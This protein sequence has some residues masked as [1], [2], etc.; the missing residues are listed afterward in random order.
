MPAT[1]SGRLNVFLSHRYHSPAENEYFWQLLSA[2]E[3]V[4]FRVDE[5]V[6]FTSPV[7]LERLIREADGFVGVHPLTGGHRE[8]HTRKSLRHESRYF[9]LELSMAVRARKPAVVFHDHRLEPALKAPPDVRFVGYDPQEIDSATQSSLPARVEAAYR[10]FLTDAHAASPPLGVGPTYQKRRVGLV[11]SLPNQQ[12]LVP[13]LSEVLH[14]HAWEPV[15]QPWPPRMNLELITWLRQ[16]DWVVIDL[17]DT[18]SRLVAAFTHGQFIPTLPVASGT[19]LDTPGTSVT[20]EE[21]LYGDTETGHRKAIIRWT[22]PTQLMHAFEAHLGVIDEQS[23]YIGR[24]DQAT[25]YFRSAAKRNERVFLSYAAEDGEQAA[26]F[27]QL[28]NDRFQDVFDYRSYGA[29]RV[30][31]P[32]MDS[33]LSGLARSAVGVLL[34]SK[35]YMS[36]KYCLLEARELYRASV[37]GRTKLVPVCLERVELPDFLQGTEYR[38]LYRHSAQVIVDELLSELRAVP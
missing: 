26:G 22:D 9:R 27:S 35:A 10:G 13:A 12:L 31:E 18:A 28:L 34:L 1:G 14:D 11:M 25:D 8:I 17:D 16:C 19:D 24:T 37:E 2:V 4:S 36:S 7:R 38:A 20:N 33:L 21:T 32:W 6:S 23:R 29:I 15:V 30:G 5:G 3:D